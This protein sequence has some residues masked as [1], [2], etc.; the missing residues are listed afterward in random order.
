MTADVVGLEEITVFRSC[1]GRTWE[2]VETRSSGGPF[3]RC[4]ECGWQVG[5][6]SAPMGEDDG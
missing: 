3:C 4:A 2:V 5:T 6:V 1:K